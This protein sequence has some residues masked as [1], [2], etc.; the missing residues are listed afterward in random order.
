MDTWTL[1][2]RLGHIIK[3]KFITFQNVDPAICSILTFIKGFVKK[4]I[5]ILCYINRINFIVWLLLLHEKLDHNIRI[6]IV[7][8]PVCDV[9]NFET[10]VFSSSHFLLFKFKYLTNKKRHFN[11]KQNTFFAIFKGLFIEPNKSN[12]FERWESIFKDELFNQ[13]SIIVN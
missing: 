11:W 6:A 9:T 2:A 4:N 5:L 12:F 8:I 1:R 7:S 10:L 3:A 13:W